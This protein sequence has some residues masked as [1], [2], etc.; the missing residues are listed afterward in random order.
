ML[1]VFTA[2]TAEVDDTGAAAEEILSQLDLPATLRQNAVG[3]LTCHPAFVE[4]GVVQALC[5]A[6]PFEVVGCT[7]LSS[8]VPGALGSLLLT[9]TMLTSD[10]ARF[11]TAVTGPLDKA[12]REPVVAAFRQAAARLDGKAAL[13]L[14]AAPVG[15]T[16]GCD[17]IQQVLGGEAP[18]MPIF[19]A[20]AMDDTVG[21][22]RARVIHKGRAH[23]DAMAFVLLAGNLAPRFALATIP[24]RNVSRRKVVVTACENNIIHEFNGIP[25]LRFLQMR[26]LAMDGSPEGL[27]AIPFLVESQDGMGPVARNVFDLT[28]EGYA[29]C[30]GDVPLNATV[31]IGALEYDDVIETTADLM[32]SVA[33]LAQG[34]SVLMFSCVC[35]NIALGVETLTEM[36]AIQTA[37]RA[38]GVPYQ[39]SY[40]GGE[41]C[42]VYDRE[43]NPVNRF[44]NSAIVA[45]I[46]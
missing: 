5:A 25:V 16:Y 35:R 18:G 38:N 4:S 29:V 28:P 45:C 14:C 24:A 21:H 17:Q 6:L 40:S 31:S 9:L 32:Q 13:M 2:H 22:Q 37:L 10:T 7:T 46:L 42:P 36:E 19:G 23:A 41:F 15:R 12:Q 1:A 3:F 34:R 27:D 20:V 43:G 33:E 26:G 11:V 44:H 8:A 30:G 39:F